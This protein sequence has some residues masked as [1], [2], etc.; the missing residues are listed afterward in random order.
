MELTLEKI[1]WILLIMMTVVVVGLYILRTARISSEMVPHK[2]YARPGEVYYTETCPTIYTD[3]GPI[4]TG[5]YV[6][7]L[8][9][10]NG[11]DKTLDK[12]YVKAEGFPDPAVTVVFG[13]AGSSPADYDIWGGTYVYAGNVNLPPRKS[14]EALV[15]VYSES[16]S[17]GASKALIIK[18]EFESGEITTLSV[19]IA[20]G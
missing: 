11:Y 9:L 15:F 20:G 13:G 19:P 14:T 16:E 2:I 10:T 18:G 17:Q 3:T 1:V 5:C 4:N 8:R 7:H 6:I 12:I